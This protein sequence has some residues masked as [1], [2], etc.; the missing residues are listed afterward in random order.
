MSRIFYELHDEAKQ[1]FGKR[2]DGSHEFNFQIRT[3]CSVAELN[4]GEIT[5]VAELAQKWREPQCP[6]E[7]YINHGSYFGDGVQ[8]IIRE[9][10]TKPTSNR[11]LY[12]LIA[13]D[14]ISNSNDDPI[15]SFLVLQCAI[16]NRVLHCTTYFRA[17][18]V[19]HFLRINIEEI[20]LTLVQICNALPDIASCE[21]VINAFRAYTNSQLGTLL[22]PRLDLMEADELLFELNENPGSFSA[23]LKEKARAQTVVDLTS[24]RH[25]QRI[26]LRAKML[27]RVVQDRLPAISSVLENAIALGESFRQLRTNG[28]HGDGVQQ[29]ATEFSTSLH[30]LADF[31][32]PRL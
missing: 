14:E 26:F 17:L 23:L 19:I 6:K 10:R 8:H 12:S 7:L 5:D 16:D 22:R 30:K 1:R 29:R 11:A 27:P 28:S 31:F 21:L 15:P 13:Q 4:A 18:E 3:S 2:A 32:E 25:L 9:L 24:L 20:R